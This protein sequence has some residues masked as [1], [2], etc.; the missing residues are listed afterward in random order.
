MIPPTEQFLDRDFNIATT[1]TRHN[2]RITA[3]VAKRDGFRHGGLSGRGNRVEKGRQLHFS[4]ARCDVPEPYDVY[5]KVRNSGREADGVG[6]LRGDITKDAGNRTCQEST[7]YRG[8]H[9]VECYI[10]KDGK[11]VASDRHL[12][13]VK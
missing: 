4:I 1:A 6:Q 10:V 5:W 13:F 12:V 9:Y 3:R 2:V 11:C 8:S 7:A